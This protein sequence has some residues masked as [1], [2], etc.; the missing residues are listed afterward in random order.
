MLPLSARCPGVLGGLHSTALLASSGR[1][2]DKQG[3]E[4]KDKTNT[5]E[6][7]FP[8]QPAMEALDPLRVC[9]PSFSLKFASPIL[10]TV[11]FSLR[12]RDFCPD[13]YY[14]LQSTAL[15]LVRL[16]CIFLRPGGTS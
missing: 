2:G 16:I 6:P 14:F 9:L 3:P 8:N 11:L 15:G 13:L 5:R 7:S 12:F 10:P 4:S 1:E